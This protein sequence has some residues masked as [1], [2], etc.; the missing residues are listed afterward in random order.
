LTEENKAFGVKL[1]E[2]EE[3]TEKVLTIIVQKFELSA[4]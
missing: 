1:N 4:K 3:K 2:A